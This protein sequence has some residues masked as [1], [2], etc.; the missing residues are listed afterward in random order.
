MIQAKH[1]YIA[2]GVLVVLICLFG[3][4]GRK[5][6]QSFLIKWEDRLL[7]WDDFKAERVVNDDFDAEVHTRLKA[8]WEPKEHELSVWAVMNPKLSGFRREM[9]DSVGT[10]Q[11]LIHE[12]YH[13]NITAYFARL[14][15][16]EL[17]QLGVEKLNKY[18]LQTL[19]HNYSR[20]IDSMQERYDLESNHNVKENEQR[21]WELYVDGLLRETAF[22]ADPNLYHYQRFTGATTPWYRNVVKGLDGQVHWALPVSE[23]HHQNGGVYL[24][25]E[26]GDSLIFSYYMN[27]E[28]A[29]DPMFETERMVITQPSKAVKLFQYLNRDGSCNTT[30]D[31]CLLKI[32]TKEDRS[33]EVLFLDSLQQPVLHHDT[34]HRIVRTF[35]A[36]QGWYTTRYYDIQG[37]AV[38]H[39]E[40]YWS[41]HTVLN[42]EG[43]G[44]SIAFFDRKGA[45]TMDASFVAKMEND[46]DE[47][48]YVTKVKKYGTNGKWATYLENYNIE[49]Q[50]DEQGKVRDYRIFNAY[51]EAIGDPSGVH[52]YQYFYDTRDHLVDSRLFNHR[53]LPVLGSDGYHQMVT[54]YDD[55]DRLTFSAKYHPKC[56]LYFSDENKGA[57]Y[58]SYPADS[59]RMEYNKGAF[60]TEFDDD[61]GVGAIR[62]TLDSLGRTLKEEYFS[63][64]GHYAHTEDGVVIKTF[65]YDDRGNL[66]ETIHYDSLQQ[67]KPFEGEA[68][69]VR[70]EYDAHNNRI[71][72]SQYR[73]ATTLAPAGSSP[74]VYRYTFDGKGRVI[75][76]EHWDENGKPY[77]LDG[78]FR[79]EFYYN[80]MGKDSVIYRYRAPG[81]LASG[82]CTVKYQYNEFGN[83][84]KERYY[85]R[86]GQLAYDEQGI[87]GLWN[88]YDPL[89]RVVA[90]Y[91]LGPDGKPNNCGNSYAKIEQHYQPLSNLVTSVAYFDVNGNPASGPDGNHM[92]LYTYNDSNV[93]Q[94]LTQYDRKGRKRN[95]SD[96][97][98]DWVYQLFDY[99]LIKRVSFY[100]AEANL[101]EDAFGVAEYL[102]SPSMNGLYFLESQWDAAGNEIPLE[103]DEVDD[104]EV[105]DET[106]I[107]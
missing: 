55:R 6:E 35:D 43:L 80:R 16:K 3:G 60:K 44:I 5:I 46:Y 70:Y 72:S 103:D 101:V 56:V 11:L 13:F 76:R 90:Q 79:K 41:D 4:S 95:N 94:R 14:L 97:I 25:E 15:R 69:I 12:Q 96:G 78:V 81:Q 50:M 68:T 23:E 98:A 93:L 92:E 71:S 67:L 106:L 102:Y 37:A 27:G 89:Q 59:L 20:K 82:Y 51:H 63:S 26:R 22:Y 100:D 10:P 42:D 7:T 83:K 58:I 30:L 17:V 53:G 104:D 34:F 65:R 64:E 33:F 49:Y 39:Y 40:G 99:G 88:E 87:Y 18:Q 52:H 45:P 31:Y 77:A 28:P 1:H 38:A 19:V 84:V 29:V 54:T 48:F 86:N 66:L 62:S 91:Q 47:N 74:A 21:Y 36:A 57:T 107:E 85:G 24:K 75:T 2:S 32:V 8:H 105:L 61:T 9:I 73:D